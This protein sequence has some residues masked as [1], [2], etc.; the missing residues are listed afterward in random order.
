[1]CRYLQRASLSSEPTELSCQVHSREEIEISIYTPSE[2][3]EDMRDLHTEE[4][5]ER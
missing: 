1:M 4:E 2:E 5:E 3:G